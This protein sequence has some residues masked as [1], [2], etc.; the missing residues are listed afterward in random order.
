MDTIAIRIKDARAKLHISQKELA[1]KAGVATST[2]GS[3]ENGR[4]RGS[5]HIVAIARA[6]KVSPD[7]LATGKGKREAMQQTNSEGLYIVA[8]SPEDLARQLSEKG[9]D[10]ILKLLQL[11][12]TLKDGDKAAE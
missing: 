11:V 8:D 1:K 10:H 12:M 2:I 9:N 6:L 3:I 7:W 4:N 5:T